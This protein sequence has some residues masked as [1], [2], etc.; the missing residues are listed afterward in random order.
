MSHSHKS[1]AHTLGSPVLDFQFHFWRLI[2]GSLTS[3]LRRQN[4]NFYFRS[5]FSWKRPVFIFKL[6]YFF[7]FNN[8]F[9]VS[10]DNSQG[11]FW[12]ETKKNRSHKKE[13]KKE[14]FTYIFFYSTK[15]SLISIYLWVCCNIAAVFRYN[16]DKQNE[17]EKK[18]KANRT[19]S[20]DTM[21]AYTA[22]N[23]NANSVRV[24]RM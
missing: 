19:H 12:Q 23:S 21:C 18:K 4:I 22:S 17:W 11:K 9:F 2:F 5:F 1:N 3:Q 14:N 16:S 13:N 7:S 15:K 8:T 24:T 10:T 20:C 6:V